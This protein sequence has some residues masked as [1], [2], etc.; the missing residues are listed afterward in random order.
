MTEVM[1][2]A[3]LGGALTWDAVTVGQFM[4]SRPLIAGGLA[5][6]LLGDPATGLLVGAILE[7]F[8]LVVVPSGGGRFPETGPAVVVGVASA[9]WVGEAGGLALGV[10]MALTL[11]QLSALT[12]GAQRHLNERWMPDAA[13]GRIRVASVGRSHLWAILLDGVRGFVVT[14]LGLL[15]VRALAPSLVS[16][17]PL[18]LDQTRALLLVGAF[19]SLGIVAKALLRGRRWIALVSGVVAGV[20]LARWLP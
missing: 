14:A 20:V 17:W 2:L 11:G 1:L 9:V 19:V 16:V 5:G 7:V 8:L 15:L 13:D 10:A 12:Q 18:P 6:F 3:L 4:I